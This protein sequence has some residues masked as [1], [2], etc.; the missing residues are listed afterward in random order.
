MGPSPSTEPEFTFELRLCQWAEREWPPTGEPESTV[1]VAR[2]LGTRGRRWDTL[3]LEC[4]PEALAARERFGLERL[5][6]DLLPVV[7]NAPAEWTYYRDA[8]PEFAPWRYVREAVNRAADRGVVERRKVGNRVQLRQRWPYPDWLK[9]LVAVENKPDLDA[10]AADTLADQ[11]QWDVAL[12]LADEAW[13]ATRAS[14]DGAERALLE[15]LPVEA[16][17]LAVGERASSVS[18]AWHAATLPVDEPGTRITERPAGGEHDQSAARFEY[19][20]PEW[21]RAKRLEIAERAYERGWRSYVDTMRPDCRQ[22]HLRR[23]AGDVLP[24][25]GAHDRS[26]TA[27]ECAGSCPHFEP[28]PPAWRSKGW[29]IEGGPGAAARRLLERRRARRR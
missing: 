12:A 20:D 22:F 23:D 1:I 9:R 4:D 27:C 13:V 2:Q 8:I 24:W 17:I 25:C 28:E 14:G 5:D 26:Q 3:V 18:V 21:K 6:S 15:G 16:G 19:V 29:P 7:R 10:S 11:L